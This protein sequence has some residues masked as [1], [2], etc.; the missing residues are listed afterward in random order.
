MDGRKWP[1]SGPQS[2]FR[3]VVL[4]G[5]PKL[6]LSTL[7]FD[8]DM[9]SPGRDGQLLVEVKATGSV[10]DRLAHSRPRAQSSF[11]GRCNRFVALIE[12]ASSRP[13]P[14]AFVLTSMTMRPALSQ[15]VSNKG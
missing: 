12:L 1:V 15:P 13:H 14:V 3:V 4:Y 7:A 8:R 10:E 11:D 6:Q 5:P 9:L 2:P